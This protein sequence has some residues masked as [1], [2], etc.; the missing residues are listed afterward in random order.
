MTGNDKNPRVKR[1]KPMTP[2]WPRRRFPTSSVDN[3]IAH[4][5]MVARPNPERNLKREYIQTFGEKI[6]RNPEVD[7]KR[8]ERSNMFLRPRVESARVER[9][10]PPTMQPIKN[11]E[12]GRLLMK[13]AAHIRFHSEIIEVSAGRSQA[14]EEATEGSGSWQTSRTERSWGA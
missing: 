9:R 4:V 6:V 12:A 13:E 1:K 5:P 10:R 7:I 11:E 8:Q 3:T 2:T 14:H